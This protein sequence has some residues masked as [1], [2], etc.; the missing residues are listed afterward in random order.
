MCVYIYFLIFT[1][2]A[3][4]KSGCQINAINKCS[5]VRSRIFSSAVQLKCEMAKRSLL[6]TTANLKHLNTDAAT[7]K[8]KNKKI[9]I[10]RQS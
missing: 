4:H 9:I 1:L 2:Q 6:P 8:V 10:V 3:T 5:G 7:E